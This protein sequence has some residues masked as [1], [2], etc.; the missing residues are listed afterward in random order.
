MLAGL[1]IAFVVSL[2]LGEVSGVRGW[3][4]NITV[5][6]GEAQEVKDPGC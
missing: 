1:E 5:F 6:K 2:C 4:W 3:A